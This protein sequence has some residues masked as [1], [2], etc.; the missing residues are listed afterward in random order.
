[1]VDGVAMAEFRILHLGVNDPVGLGDGG[2]LLGRAGEADEPR[3]EILHVV[4]HD[5]GRVTLGIEGDEDGDNLVGLVAQLS[6]AA[7]ITCSSVGQTSGQWVKPK[8]T[9]M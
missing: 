1:M 8:K 9:S 6:S 2:D 7:A 3:M 5:R 4:G